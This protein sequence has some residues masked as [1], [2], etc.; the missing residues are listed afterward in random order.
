[1]NE[2]QFAVNIF[3]QSGRTFIPVG[4]LTTISGREL[5]KSGQHD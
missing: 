3:Q 2:N 1:M 5:P 4:S